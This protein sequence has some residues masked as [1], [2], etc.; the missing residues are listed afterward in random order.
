MEIY[1]ELKKRLKL[2]KL[3]Q[4]GQNFWCKTYNLLY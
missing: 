2:S 3:T 4:P 1:A